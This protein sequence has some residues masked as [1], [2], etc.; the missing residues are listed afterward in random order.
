MS[1]EKFVYNKQTLQYEK[2]EESKQERAVR[3]F[4]IIS[5]CIV[6]LL[7]GM[8]VLMQIGVIP[9]FSELRRLQ[10]E[11]EQ[12]RTL[13]DAQGNTVDKM[14]HVL[15]NVQDRDAYVHRVMFN[16]KPVD[17]D[18]WQGGTGGSDQN[19]DIA[20][21]TS[22]RSLSE[23]RGKIQQLAY[24]LAIQS[25]SLDTLAVLAKNKEQMFASIPSI[26]PVREDQLARSVSLLSGFGM[27]FH[28]IHR[29]MKFHKGI[30]F[31]AD[32]GTP[33]QATG[34]GEVIEAGRDGGYGNTVKIDHGFGYVTL[35]GHM[36]QIDVKMGQRIKKGQRI[37]LVGSTGSST[38]PHCHYEVHFHGKPVNPVH[39]VMDGL[40]T[41]EYQS[42]SDAARRTNKSFD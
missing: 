41:M 6:S 40:S 15:Q 10:G 33:I 35:Y 17:K 19:A 32:S 30:D 16:M 3:I 42:L 13:V 29:V 23:T 27:R 28:P 24:Q 4:G 18:V 39:F 2:I 36:K 25:R 7:M 9:S 31:T 37:G 20:H 34:D 22:A 1:K 26:K 21:F 14:S 12:L 38:G 11:N 8:F 5:A